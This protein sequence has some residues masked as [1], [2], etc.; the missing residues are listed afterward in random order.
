M[1]RLGCLLTASAAAVLFAGPSAATADQATDLVARGIAER[2]PAGWQIRVRWRNDALTA[3]VTAPTVQQSFDLFY[4]ARRQA[5]LIS[6]LCPSAPDPVWNLLDVR[7]DIAIEPE[8]MGKGGLRVS[9]RA[10]LREAP[11]S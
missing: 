1:L 7:Q 11:A 5:D 10:T 3:F 2:A 8:V 4:D 6:R 9:C